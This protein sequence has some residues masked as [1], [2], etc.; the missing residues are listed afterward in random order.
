MLQTVCCA[1]F[2]QGEYHFM[3]VFFST[4]A[5][6]LRAC[7]FLKSSQVKWIN[8]KCAMHYDN[9][10]SMDCWKKFFVYAI[11][12]MIRNVERKLHVVNCECWL[13]KATGWMHDVF[14]NLIAIKNAFSTAIGSEHHFRAE[15]AFDL[16]RFN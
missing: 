7:Q 12:E 8:F 4:L 9:N 2:Q 6:H 14:C 15:L 13:K 1:N 10:R 16:I 5:W 3:F 11:F